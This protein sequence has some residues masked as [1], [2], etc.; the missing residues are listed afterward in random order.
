MNV[1]RFILDI[2]FFSTSNVVKFHVVIE[3]PS[4]GPLQ[5]QKLNRLSENSLEKLIICLSCLFQVIPVDLTAERFA[6]VCIRDITCCHSDLL[7]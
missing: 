6:N 2:P 5:R 4:K 7:P 1:L 3:S